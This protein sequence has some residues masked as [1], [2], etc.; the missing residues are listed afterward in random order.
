MIVTCCSLPV[1]VKV[2][3]QC[4]ISDQVTVPLEASNSS[5]EF[6]VRIAPEIGYKDF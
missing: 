2:C 1:Q 6:G 5:V 3:Q 4:L